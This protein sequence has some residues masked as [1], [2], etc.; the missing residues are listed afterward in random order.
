MGRLAGRKRQPTDDYCHLSPVMTK[1]LNENSQAN[2]HVKQF[3]CRVERC[4]GHGLN[5]VI[6]LYCNG[7]ITVV[8]MF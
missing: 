3:F 6:M 1:L 7:E 8:G 5:A 2:R 4:S